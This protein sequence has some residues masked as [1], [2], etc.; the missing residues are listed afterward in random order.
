MTKRASLPAITGIRFFLAMWVVVLH[1][2]ATNP[3]TEGLMRHMPRWIAESVDAGA[4]AVGIF[5]L[6]SGFVLAYTYDLGVAWKRGLRLRFW[7]ARFARIYPVYFLALLLGLPALFA[8][9]LKSSAGIQRL[10]L[11]GGMAAVLLLVQSWIP[12]DALLWGGPAWSLSAEAFFYLCFPF[13]GALLWRVS[14]T[15]SMLLALI[16][17]WLTVCGLSYGIAAVWAP[18]F[19]KYGVGGETQWTEV[20]KFN[21]LVRLPEFLAGIVLCKLYLSLKERREGW[22]R[23]G[24]GAVL[25][26][27]GMLALV[28]IVSQQEH[29][30]P[31]VLHDGLMLPASAAMILGLSLGGGWI[32]RLLS[33]PTLVVLGQAS[34]AVYLLHMPV[35]SFFAASG[36][37]LAHTATGQWVV[38]VAYLVCLMGVCLLAF[39]KLEEPARKGILK[40][41]DRKVGLKIQAR[42][43]EP[44]AAD[45]F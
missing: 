31:A 43:P 28:A 33:R 22:F 18:W 29:L 12:D 38:L 10:P 36:K 23:P 14:R 17:L 34:Y 35:Y 16:G 15:R 27:P 21:P 45:P 40:I 19:L 42:E 8:G 44:A 5:F 1:M 20:I 41:F 4:C 11:A 6:L 2:A 9:L 13:L 26:V 37:R 30:P 7:A 32:A 39:F 25:Y 3:A 24:R